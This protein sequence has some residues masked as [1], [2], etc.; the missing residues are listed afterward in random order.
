MYAKTENIVI[1][2]NTYTPAC[3]SYPARARSLPA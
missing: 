1:H 2:N 3:E